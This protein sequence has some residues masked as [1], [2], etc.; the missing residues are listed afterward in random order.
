MSRISAIIG[1]IFLFLVTPVMGKEKFSLLDVTFPTLKGNF[2][3]TAAPVNL[4][5]R[6][7]LGSELWLLPGGK[8]SPS[9]NPVED[10]LLFFLSIKGLVDSVTFT[11]GSDSERT[12][13]VA[14]S[15][16][17]LRFNPARL[18]NKAI[19]FV[20]PARLISGR[21]FRQPRATLYMPYNPGS[22]IKDRPLLERALELNGF[23][24]PGVNLFPSYFCHFTANQSN[25]K[26]PF[27]IFKITL[28][29][30]GHPRNFSELLSTNKSFSR[31][32]ATAILYASFRPAAY[33]GKPVPSILF[34]IFRFFDRIEY[35][36]T[37][38][39]PSDSAGADYPLEYARID[40]C[41]YLDSIIN[42]PLPLNTPGGEFTF[43]LESMAND[44]I[45]AFVKIDT[46]GNI[47]AMIFDAPDFYP[48]VGDG[49]KILR[50]LRFFPGRN[51]RDSLL[52]Y[53]GKVTLAFDGS[54]NIRIWTDWLRFDGLI[55]KEV[56]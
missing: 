22:G 12:G 5:D 19:P 54:R 45:S 34:L 56:K 49:K 55:K 25:A 4:W 53:D 47:A 50:K 29:S 10:Q 41:L 42:P 17:A 44:T 9:E 20:L 11:P 33:N 46:L 43:D 15:L 16:K 13:G 23:A 52:F 14:N 8:I 3:D 27:A 7:G 37:S 1:L 30:S 48:P 31:T 51:I 18:K 36:T 28:D 6:G 39:P 21:R 32:V 35:P 26:Y 38:W 2:P 40:P 24:L